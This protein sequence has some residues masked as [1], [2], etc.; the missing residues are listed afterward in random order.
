MTNF[1]TLSKIFVISAKKIF[2]WY[3]EVLS[4]YASKEVQQEL[5]KNDLKNVKTRD[6]KTNKRKKIKVPILKPQN[7]GKNMAIDDKN[8]GGETY[9]IIS[10][11]DTGKIAVMLMSIKS[12]IIDKVLS[13]IPAKILFSVKTITAD[14]AENYDWVCRSAFINATKIADKFHVIKLALEACMI[15]ITC[16][17]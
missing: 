1:S 9:T 7:F 6:K 8:I 2:R 16:L 13:T 12:N 4:G 10:N 3:K 17:I 11:K 5:H 14:L 15:Q